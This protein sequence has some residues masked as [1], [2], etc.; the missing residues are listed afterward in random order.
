MGEVRVNLTNFI[1]VGLM[2]FAFTWAA[3]KVLRKV[4][5]QSATGG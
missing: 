5:G 3:N 1:T 2:A 4:A